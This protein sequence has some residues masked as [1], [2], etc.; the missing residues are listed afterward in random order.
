MD[1]S[2]PTPEKPSSQEATASPK[3]VASRLAIGALI[4]A[5][6]GYAWYHF[7]GCPTGTCAMQANPIVM[8]G[9]GGLWGLLIA[10]PKR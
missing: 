8:T 3:K 5:A 6:G 7:V 2:T 1:E 9:F 10:S 4:G